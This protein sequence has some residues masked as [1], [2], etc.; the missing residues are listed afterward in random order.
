MRL[1]LKYASVLEHHNKQSIIP[2]YLCYM[3]AKNIRRACKEKLKILSRRLHRC[4]VNKC[5][6]QIKMLGHSI[7]AHF[8]LSHHLI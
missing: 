6:R 1:I 4:D 3:A 7:P 8:V 2:W 5:L